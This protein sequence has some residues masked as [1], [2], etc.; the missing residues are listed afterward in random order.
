MRLPTAYAGFLVNI[1]F[2]T[3]A[4]VNEEILATEEYIGLDFYPFS[5]VE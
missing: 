4:S 2:L 5:F 3:V 1:F